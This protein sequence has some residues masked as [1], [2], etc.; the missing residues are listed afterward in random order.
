MDTDRQDEGA[1]VE[2]AKPASSWVHQQNL[3]GERA[4]LCVIFFLSSLQST[5]A[6]LALL[7]L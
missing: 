6:L 3:E 1:S 7:A 5:E 4:T 2:E